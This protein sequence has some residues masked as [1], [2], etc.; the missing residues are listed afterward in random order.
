MVCSVEPEIEE[1]SC[2]TPSGGAFE[3]RVASSGGNNTSPM[4]DHDGSSSMFAVW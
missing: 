3:C 2:M 4:C 1:D